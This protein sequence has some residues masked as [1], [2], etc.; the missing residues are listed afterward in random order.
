MIF[1]PFLLACQTPEKDHGDIR[2]IIERKEN[3]S[4]FYVTKF[5][6]FDRDGRVE[7]YGYGKG[8]PSGISYD[9]YGINENTASFYISRAYAESIGFKEPQEK[10]IPSSIPRIMPY[11]MEERVNRSFYGIERGITPAYALLVQE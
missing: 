2:I 9:P 4:D 6:D 10:R 7:L 5:I 3:S 1:F 11:T 8:F